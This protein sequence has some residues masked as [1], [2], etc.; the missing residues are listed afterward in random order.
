M[1]RFRQTH[2]LWHVLTGYA[3]DVEGEILLQAFTY[4]QTGVPSALLIAALGTLRWAKLA[5]SHARKLLEAHRRGK[6]TAR[7][8]TFRWERHWATPV[9]TLRRELTCPV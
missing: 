5:P 8:A 3:P 7:L 6:A 4:A 2:D 1:L 9:E